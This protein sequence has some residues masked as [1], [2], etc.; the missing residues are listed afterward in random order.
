M[1]S[2]VEEVLI[3]GERV[4]HRARISLWPFAMHILIGVV[5]AVVVVGLLVLAWVYVKV[6]ATEVAITTKRIIVKEGLISR[7]TVE[8]NLGKVES[9]RVDQTILGR[10]LNYGTLVIAGTGMAAA[11]IQGIA[12]P[13][14][15]RKQFMAA[16]DQST[17]SNRA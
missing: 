2:Y 15:F 17:E 16:A 8:I 9:V 12:N 4:L 6:K 14:A 10:M 11:P 13:L 1:S 3:P 7:S 5:L